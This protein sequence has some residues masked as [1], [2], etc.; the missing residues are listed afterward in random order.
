MKTYTEYINEMS[1]RESKRYVKSAA[2]RSSS[3][4]GATVEATVDELRLAFGEPEYA[5]GD[6]KVNYEWL[7]ETEDGVYFT[8]YD[9]KEGRKI[10]EYEMIRWHIGGQDFSSSLE[11]KEIV[12]NEL[13]KIRNSKGKRN[14]NSNI[15]HTPQ[16]IINRYNEIEEEL[17]SLEYKLDM[18]ED[19][20]R[21]EIQ[22]MIDDLE[23]EKESLAGYVE[24]YLSIN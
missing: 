20:E 5:S 21:D 22:Q 7:L 9:W 6:S 11:G 18:A 15:T 10:K 14:V 24:E 2:W 8:I 13:L 16:A 19:F 1:N 23:I 17:Y 3:F 4:H 12:E